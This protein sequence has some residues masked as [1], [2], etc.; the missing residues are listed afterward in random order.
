M[1]IPYPFLKHIFSAESIWIIAVLDIVMLQI[2]AFKIC[3]LV[4]HFI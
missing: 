1:S 2:L 3:N 4:T